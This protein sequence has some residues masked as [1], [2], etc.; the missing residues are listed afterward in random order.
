MTSLSPSSDLANIA[1]ETLNQAWTDYLAPLYSN[2]NAGKK[3]RL[4]Q[5]LRNL[6]TVCTTEAI[7]GPENPF[8]KDRTLVEDFWHFDRNVNVFLVNMCPNII[9]PRAFKARTRMAR[10]FE[11]YF[12]RN[13]SSSGSVLAKER[14]SVGSKYGFRKPD[15]GHMELGVVTALLVNTVPTA[16][17]YLM[18]IFRSP[19]LLS[20]LRHE[21]DHHAITRRTDERGHT[22]ETLNLDRV[23]RECTLLNSTLHEVLRLY[24]EIASARLVLEDTLLDNTHLLTRNAIVQIPNTIL[25][26]DGKVWGDTSFRPDRFIDSSE[27]RPRI[28]QTLTSSTSYRPFGGGNSLCP[29]RHYAAIE[30]AGLAALMIWKFDLR[31][32]G[33]G[34]LE[35]PTPRQQSVVEGVSPPGWDVE[36]DIQAREDGETGLEISYG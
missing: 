13:G 18:H 32:V 15:M 16:F 8:F 2:P 3:V 17:Y 19:G 23:R 24:S 36:V 27:P 29:G 10:A 5:F 28:A 25:H 7:Y 9:A 34:R 12:S 6:L 1:V 20:Q 26:Q 33:E 21:V 31:A 30:M 14:Y 11:R 22:V 4:H 35:I